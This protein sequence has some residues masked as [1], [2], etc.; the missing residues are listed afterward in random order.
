MRLD[1]VPDLALV[2]LNPSQRRVLADLVE[3]ER[4]KASMWWTFLNEMRIRGEL[5]GWVKTQS[6]GT[7]SDH[8]D[9]LQLGEEV[10][11]AM[12]GKVRHIAL[13]G[14]PEWVGVTLEGDKRG[15]TQRPCPL[16][17]VQG[18]ESV[19]QLQE[20]VLQHL[21][22]DIALGSTNERKLS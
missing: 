22:G 3:A 18:A 21:S 13:Q 15:L 9:W 1:S 11:R 19:E 2:T 5:P 4:S 7:A 16:Q 14:E 6:V 20:K 17:T 10:H 12:F 8:D